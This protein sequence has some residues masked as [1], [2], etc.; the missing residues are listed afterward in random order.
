[1]L[2]L[3]FVLPRRPT[4]MAVLAVR[5]LQ[6]V[7]LI[8]D[9]RQL[10]AFVQQCWFPLETTHPSIKTSLFER[11]V[12]AS[13]GDSAA[14]SIL[15]EQ[16]RMRPAIADLTR[17]HYQDVVEIVDHE[18]TISQRVGDRI[19]KDTIQAERQLWQE[20]GAVQRPSCHVS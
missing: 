9:H 7:E 12:E 10:P 14:R 20:E 11:L 8:G 17:S 13:P 4:L 3:N 16:R 15:D 1:M 18:C 19:S 5:S 2:S 6:F